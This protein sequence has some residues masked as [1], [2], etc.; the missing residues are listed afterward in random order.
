MSF[1]TFQ[2]LEGAAAKRIEGMK[3]CIHY[4][5]SE[6]LHTIAQDTALQLSRCF[7]AE[8]FRCNNEAE[9]LVLSFMATYAD[10]VA[11]ELQSITQKMHD[12]LLERAKKRAA[13]MMTEAVKE[14]F[15]P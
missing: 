4:L 2:D 15:T 10:L 12:V 11:D 3:P 6:Q 1:Y 13:E 8:Y 5:S 9:R 14:G 7:K